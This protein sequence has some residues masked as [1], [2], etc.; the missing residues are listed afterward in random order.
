MHDM[1]DAQRIHASIERAR[2]WRDEVRANSLSLS[3]RFTEELV[4]ILGH[5]PADSLLATMVDPGMRAKALRELV[6]SAEK[7]ASREDRAS[8]GVVLEPDRPAED[9]ID[10]ELAARIT[11]VIADYHTE[12]LATTIPSEPTS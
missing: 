2:A 12:R 10:D 1:T 8:L 3:R 9:G 11:R 7:L 4:R 5:T 6:L